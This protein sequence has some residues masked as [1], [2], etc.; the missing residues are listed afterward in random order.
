MRTR[1]YLKIL[2]CYLIVAFV[3]FFPAFKRMIISRAIEN[4]PEDEVVEER[5]AKI[6]GT[7][8]RLSV[9]EIGID[10]PVIPGDFQDKSWKLTKDK[11]QFAQMTSEPNDQEGNSLFYGHNTPLVFKKTEQL[12]V[13]DHLIVETSNNLKFVYR[14]VNSEYV[15][16]TN[17]TVFA[18]KG[19]SQA[20]LLTCN[21]LFNSKRRLMYFRF[22]KV[23]KTL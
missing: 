3:F 5:V 23:I 18:Y 20:T 4:V 15:Q 14:Y 10:L 1:F 13:G 16:P 11:S 6:T 21:G 2:C 12:S 19:P 9:P 7:P 22:E 8:V 17:T